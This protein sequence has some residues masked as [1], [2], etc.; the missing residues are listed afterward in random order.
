ML[1]FNDFGRVEELATPFWYYDMD[2]FR[3]TV[4]LAASLSERYGIGAHYAL[5]ANVEP[6][7]VSYI[8][9]KGF[10]ADCVSGNEVKYAVESG[11]ARSSIVFAG[12]GKSDKEISDALDL[13]IGCFNVES[14]MEMQVIDALAASKGVRANVSLRINPNIDAHTHRYVTTGLYENKF[15]ISRHEFEAAIDILK[16]SKALDFKGLHFH[17]GSQI[18]DVEPV[19]SLECERAA[20]IVE[21]F[22]AHGMEVGSIDL[23]GGLGVDYDEPDENPVPD[24]EKWF[25]IIDRKLKRRPEQSVSIEPGRSMV[26]QCGSLITRV[27]FVKSGETKTF[28][29]MD[30]G[31]N[32]LI[33]PAL[34][35]AYHK[36]ENLSAY[37]ASKSSSD[38]MKN[39]SKSSSDDRPGPGICESKYVEDVKAARSV[40]VWDRVPMKN[41]EPVG[42]D[43]PL[44]KGVQGGLRLY[45]V[46]GPVCE[47]S[48]VWGEGR[49]LPYSKRGDILAIRST[50]AYGSVMSSRYNLR[51]LAP[52]VFSDDM[53]LK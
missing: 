53:K 7:L 14:L 48:D 36:I 26:A 25:S 6:R 10:G 47:S 1:K 16:G 24:F 2:V 34:Y 4:K 49:E 22:E 41:K 52:A 17:I 5:K 40:R 51:D 33:R 31:M 37:Y 28:L 50:G 20:E 27:L 35:G 11:F 3:K 8:A 29:I 32:D 12:V 42:R 46:V 18:T 43:R 44:E 19:Y 21:W 38:E 9:S 39:Y 23:G 30:A 15:G 45:D 13:G